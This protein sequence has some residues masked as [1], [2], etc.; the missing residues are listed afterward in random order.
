MKS[1]HLVA[2]FLYTHADVLI[3]IVFD[4]EPRPDIP[5]I[6]IRI[7]RTDMVYVLQVKVESALANVAPNYAVSADELD[8]EHK[9]QRLKETR[10]LDFYSIT[11]G[12]EVVACADMCMHIPEPPVRTG[13][14]CQP[15][16]CCNYRRRK[17]ACLWAP[18]LYAYQPRACRGNP[19]GRFLLRRAE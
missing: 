15:P 1:N 18:P 11:E 16:A 14:A 8:L 12:S 13:Y 2:S 19:G 17:T 6:Y 5:Q 9:G 3:K 4:A 10:A 7:K